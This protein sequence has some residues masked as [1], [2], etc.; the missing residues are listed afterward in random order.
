ME[1]DQVIEIMGS[2]LRSLRANDQDVWVYSYYV[3]EQRSGATITFADNAVF[4]IQKDMD[5]TLT[6]QLLE[7]PDLGTYKRKVLQ[8]RKSKKQFKELK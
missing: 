4:E 5:K 8:D 1:K 3:D 6:E 7:A 2:P